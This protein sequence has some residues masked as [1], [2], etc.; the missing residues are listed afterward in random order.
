LVHPASNLNNHQKIGLLLS[1]DLCQCIQL[2]DGDKFQFQR[3]QNILNEFQ[4]YI[5]I[6]RADSDSLLAITDKIAANPNLVTLSAKILIL[7]ENQNIKKIIV[8]GFETLLRKLVSQPIPLN[9]SIFPIIID[10]F[11][12]EAETIARNPN[13]STHQIHRSAAMLDARLLGK[14]PM[15]AN[16]KSIICFLIAACLGAVVGVVFSAFTSMDWE[17]GFGA[18][19]ESF[20][21]RFSDVNDLGLSTGVGVLGTAGGVAGFFSAKRNA[22]EYADKSYEID[23]NSTA[24]DSVRELNEAIRNK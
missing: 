19:A 8:D 4:N 15:G 10:H 1:K 2:I 23:R 14:P 11:T 12:Q 5:Y 3:D 24:L 20:V 17:G 22:S 13:R 18:F 21:E 7:K 9:E 16:L 6:D